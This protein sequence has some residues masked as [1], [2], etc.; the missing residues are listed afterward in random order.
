MRGAAPRPSRGWGGN[1][2]TRRPHRWRID[3]TG[4]RRRVGQGCRRRRP[5]GP[6]CAPGRRRRAGARR[7]GRGSWAGR[8][9]REGD[10]GRREGGSGAGPPVIHTG[11]EQPQ[12]AARVRSGPA[13]E[14]IAGA[15]RVVRRLAHGGHGNRPE[16]LRPVVGTG[17]SGDGHQQCRLAIGP[18]RR[19]Q[20]IR[21]GDAQHLPHVSRLG[22]PALPPDKHMHQPRIG[23]ASWSSRKRDA[24]DK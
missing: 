11:D 17:L 5:G 18:G 2:R 14:S 10:G 24:R 6:G 23:H 1:Q 3:G 9:R 22:L 19:A 7:H 21:R 15:V 4:G 13:G 8:R 16:V 20:R 12:V